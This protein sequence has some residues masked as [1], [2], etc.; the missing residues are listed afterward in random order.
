MAY[1]GHS[2]GTTQMFTALSTNQ[3][4]FKDK[5]PLFVALGPVSKISHTQ[6][7]VFQWAAE[8]YNELADTCS[9][10]G[11]HSILDANWFTSTVSQLFCSNIPRFCELIEL[12]FA[13]HNPTLDDA[14]RFGVYMGH[15]PNGASIKAILHYAQN[16]KEDRF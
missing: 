10:L 2:Q 7:A 16:L 14:D 11:I 9:L 3:D 6:A 8:F 1:V 13:S 12:L 15:E 4:Y 5:V